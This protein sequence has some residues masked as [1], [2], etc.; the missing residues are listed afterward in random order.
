M[1]DLKS[2]DSLC[3]I[4]EKRNFGFN[5][6]TNKWEWSCV[7]DAGTASCF[8]TKRS[9]Q[10]GKCGLTHYQCETSFSSVENKDTPKLDNGWAWVCTGKEGGDSAQ[11]LQC[12]DGYER[13]PN[14][15]QGYY[16]GACVKK[17]WYEWKCVTFTNT[18]GFCSIPRSYDHS[19][20][21]QNEPTKTPAG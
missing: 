12:E 1:D 17:T 13:K 19:S 4:G 11:C 5:T 3:D 14:L 15:G 7:G 9:P 10:G 16:N 2:T 20:G 8:A 21:T 18:T 6:A